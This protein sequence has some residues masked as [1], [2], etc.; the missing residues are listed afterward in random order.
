MIISLAGENYTGKTAF[1]CSFPKKALHIET[2]LGGF[3]RVVPQ[4]KA[5]VDAGDII[6]I[7]YP[8]PKETLREN[9]GIEISEKVIG[10]RELW[11]DM[12]TKMCTAF[13]D[14]EF[15]SVIFD[16]F[17]NIH[18]Y[19]MDAQVQLNQERQERKGEIKNGKGYRGALHLTEFRFVNTKMHSI[20]D[21]AIRCNTNLILIHHMADQYGMVQKGDKVEE[22][23][24][25]RGAKGWKSC[26]L[27]ASDLMDF[28]ILM[29][30][31]DKKRVFGNG[32]QDTNRFY[33]TIEKAGHVRG[34]KGLVLEDPTYDMLMAHINMELIKQGAA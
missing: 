20:V 28:V 16:T 5:V 2:D 34:L 10:M 26:G 24:I 23:V 8:A 4:F 29:Q 17:S 19:C 14:P 21:E 3:A 12:C 6:S 33:G 7:A 31:G 13:D 1:A 25:G 15:G 11:I 9:L 32:K 30:R 22:A 18:P 27:G